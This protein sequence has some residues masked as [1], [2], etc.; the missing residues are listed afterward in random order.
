MDEIR[1][2]DQVILYDRRLTAAAYSAVP[3]GDAERCGCL[4][5]QNFAA[6]GSSVYPDAFRRLLTQIGIDAQKEG[7]VYELGRQGDLRIYCGWFYFSGEVVEPGERNTITA[8]DFQ[9]Y[10]RDAK[11]LPKPDADFGDKVAAVEFQTRLA[12]ALTDQP[13]PL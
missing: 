4:Y 9:H 10:F 7:E 11:Q 3:G 13:E 1:S 8:P 5:C 6:Q 2:G 12:W